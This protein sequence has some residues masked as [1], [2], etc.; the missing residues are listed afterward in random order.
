MQDWFEEVERSKNE[1]LITVENC[2]D[3]IYSHSCSDNCYCDGALVGSN[4]GDF[5]N[6][7]KNFAVDQNSI[8]G[9]DSSLLEKPS[10]YQQIGRK[11]KW[12]GR[13]RRR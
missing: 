2:G 3:D 4:A 10:S 7:D 13:R 5:K 6:A 12:D 11:K 9:S 8:K 1:K